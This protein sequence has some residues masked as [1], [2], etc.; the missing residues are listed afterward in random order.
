MNVYLAR[1]LGGTEG[2]A[3]GPLPTLEQL[4]ED[5]IA[6]LLA[7]TRHNV[8]RVAEISAVSR[9]AVYNRVQKDTTRGVVP[10]Q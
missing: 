1:Y 4:K 10:L 6:Y 5:Y 8:A 7:L 2:P 9:T 3:R